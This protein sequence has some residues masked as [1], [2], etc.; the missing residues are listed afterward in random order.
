MTTKRK[1]HLHK[2]QRVNIGSKTKPYLVYRCMKPGCTHY[3]TPKLALN[4]ACECN[5]C[6]KIMVLTKEAL[7]LVKPHCAGCVERKDSDRL[8]ALVEGLEI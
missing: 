4:R 2:Y 5:R 7:T 6:G 8:S 1:K 3:I